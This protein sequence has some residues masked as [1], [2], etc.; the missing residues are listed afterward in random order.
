MRQR[1]ESKQPV[2]GRRANR[3]RA[4]TKARTIAAPSVSDL[5][6][7]VSNL[8]SELKEALEFQIATGEVLRIVA[9][10][11]EHLQSVFDAM[12]E[13]AIALCDA[14]FG[15]LF[16][17]DGKAFTVAADRN[18]PL[19][20]ARAVRGQSFLPEANSGFRRLVESKALLHVRELLAD[21]TY[22]KHEPL[23]TAA[24]E[25]GGVRS[26]LA[27]PLLRK[28]DLIGNFSIYGAEP[29]GFAENQIALV[30]T[31]AD[32]A[33]IAIE[34]A[35]L[36]SELRQR[37]ADLSASLQ[38]Q[39]ATADVLKVISR[40]AFD[41]QTVLE[42]L[43]D[44]AV[45]LSGALRGTIFL[46]DGDLFRFRAASYD[47]NPAWLNFLKDNPQRAGR[48]SAIGRAI[49]TGQTICVPDMAADPEIDIPAYALAGTRA[50]LATPL[51]RDGKVEGAM[52]L[53]RTTPGPF[54]QRQIELVQTFAD[55]AVIAIENTRLFNETKEALERQTATAE[56]LKVIASSPSNVQP[57]FDAIA[58]SA[59]RLIGGFST[60][61]HRVIDDIVHLVAFTPTNPESDEALKA[62]F[63]RHRSEVPTVAL[64]ENG[65]TLQFAD[66]ETADAH[67]RRLGRARGWRSVTFTPLMNQGAFIGFIACTRRE[68]GVLAD[69]HVQ[70]LRT[71]ANQAVIAIENAR[72][73][74]ELRQRTDDLSESLQQQTAT[75]EVLQ[76]ISSSPG[77]LGPVFDK[78]LEN[79]TRVCGAEF[80]SMIL[81]EG[82]SV[83]QAALYNAPA[84]FAAARAN[85]TFELHPLSAPAIAMRNRQ[86]VQIE[87]VRQNA[88]YLA[89]NPSSV[90]LVELGGARTVVSVPMLREDEVIGLI[91]V[92][93]QE[94]RLFGDK[95]IELLTNF[96]RQAVIAIENARLLRELRQRTDDLTEALVYQ[97]GSGN[98]LKV[99]ASSPTDVN[100][101][102]KAIVESAR[103]IC[104][105]YDAAVVLKDGEDLVVSAHYGPIPPGFARQPIS[106]TWITGRAVLDKVPQH[107]HD[108]LGPEGD[109]FPDARAMGR[110]Q[111]YRTVLSV[112]LLQEGEAIG[113]IVLRRVEVQPFSDKQIELL[114]SFAD[115]A[116]IAISNVRLFEQVQERTRELSKSLDDLRT[117]QD[118]LIQTEKL[119]SLG[120]L[121]AGIAHEIKNPLNFVNN[122][123]ALSVELTEELNDVLRQAELVETIR[124]E[125]DELIGMLKDNLS[126]IVQHGKRAD[127]IVKN[128]LLHSREGSREQRPADVNALVEESLNLAYHGARAEKS[129]FEI[130]LQRDLDANAGMVEVFPQDVSRALLNLISN[131]FYAATKRKTENGGAGIEPT[132]LATTKNLGS[133][134]EIRIRD[135]GTGIPPEVKEKMFNPFFTTKPTGEGTGLGLS[136]THDII[137]KQ[138][139][140]RIDVDTKVGEFTEFIITLPR[141]NRTAA[142]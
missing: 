81:A 136:M 109:D 117:A 113:A 50:V 114:K 105:A 11:P 5:Q 28:G 60:A 3:P 51:Q 96:A 127:S 99:I 94:V 87:D 76:V 57:V 130:T 4:R 37:T 39:T 75:S 58:S 59:N 77:E 29:G 26:L 119:A 102:L 41:L 95:Q 101:A 78:M 24:I 79:A 53:V 32:Q 23:R 2:K 18:L 108:L 123:S 19:A 62:A 138:H 142:G 141:N 34:N 121:T 71:F 93:R 86:V 107:A 6:K 7:Q 128:M 13:K 31:F 21:P 110:R 46:R 85:K 120:Q 1:G 91:T 135:N 8:T 73:L 44:S 49:A 55:Q 40:S 35:R 129:G 89:S 82:D 68:T 84:A 104:G 88:P 137:V 118:R 103:E 15:T 45:E 125:T 33:V 134:V 92:Y 30:T 124:K 38:Q 100:P 131:G 83:R 43:L 122:F 27:V 67:T 70:L 36:L 74:R 56:I 9:S 52:A 16:L 115:Q 14:K 48:H 47:I 72:L 90:A 140:G 97:T 25:L 111:G 132:V 98:I 17:Y 64:V 133:S 80:G 139:G 10:S 12:L 126:K 61:V 69:H 65:E 66:A 116:V 54:T 42:T 22:A 63:P 106:R 112:P 20:Y